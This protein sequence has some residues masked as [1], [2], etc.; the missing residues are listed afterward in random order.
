M[1]SLHK[2]HLILEVR[3]AVVGVFYSLL[4]TH[5]T[6]FFKSIITFLSSVVW[7]FQTQKQQAIPVVL[8]L[9][10]KQAKVLFTGE[11]SMMTN[12]NIAQC[13]VDTTT[14]GLFISKD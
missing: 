6:D 12:E 14:D 1:C 11:S 5:F 13:I 7:E 8:K 10:H 3:L 4:H 9:G 2:G